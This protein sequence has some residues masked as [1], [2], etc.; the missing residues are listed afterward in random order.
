MAIIAE[1]KF[2]HEIEL[3]GD[4]SKD[5]RSFKRA[6]ERA[7]P[8]RVDLCQDDNRFGVLRIP[9][10]HWMLREL[11]ANGLTVGSKWTL[12]RAFYENS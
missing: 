1:R 3:T 10:D 7:G 9:E 8:L 2:K 11:D 4:W 12:N 5:L 6:V